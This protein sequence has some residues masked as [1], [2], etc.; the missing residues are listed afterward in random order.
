MEKMKNILFSVLAV[1]LLAATGFGS[2]WAW[3]ELVSSQSTLVNLSSSGKVYYKP[4]LAEASVSVVT[5]GKEPQTVQSDNDATMTGILDYLKTAGVKE[6]DIK[7]TGYYL[8]PEYKTGPDGA[9]NTLEIIGYTLSQNIVFKVREI[10]KVPEIIGGLPAKGTNTINGISF[11]LSDEKTEELKAQAMEKAVAKTKQE[12]EKTK[13][14]YGFRKARLINISSYPT[15]YGN[16]K[17]A[18]GMGGDGGASLAPIQPGTGELE[19][20]VS[21]VYELK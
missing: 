11:F 17:M 14:L 16:E 3:N 15:F 10:S 21:L 7:T 8:Y 2:V 6:E 20:Q 1:F 9:V 4:D 13:A 19:M 5:K 18:L 12:L